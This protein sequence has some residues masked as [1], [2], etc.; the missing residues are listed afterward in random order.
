MSVIRAVALFG[1]LACYALQA[2]AEE[3]YWVRIR[4]LLNEAKTREDAEAARNYVES[5]TAEQLIIAGRQCGH[6]IQEGI[7]A[8]RPGAGEG[9]I[10]LA[11]FWEAYPRA[12]DNLRD[13]DPLLREICDRN[14]PAVWRAELARSLLAVGDDDELGTP[15]TNEQRQQV[16]ASLEPILG[17]ST[18][19]LRVRNAIPLSLARMLSAMYKD[20]SGAARCAA[21]DQR[22]QSENSLKEL[23]GRI[24]RY[25]ENTLV[26]FH[27]P[28]T[29]TAP[30]PFRQ[31][32]LESALICNRE[33]LP[34]SARVKDVVLG[35]LARYQQYPQAL[36][37][38]L[39]WAAIE[40]FHDPSAQDVLEEMIG[41][42]SN[43]DRN[44]VK[45]SLQYIKRRSAELRA[46]HHAKE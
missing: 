37:P 2:S 21:P 36:W 39:A 42:A 43:A 41:E 28:T 31:R 34:G 12:A 22:L 1:S 14:R 3:D 9:V 29:P 15:L 16:F 5:L 46:I 4:T 6:E 11:F 18:D 38:Q 35:A 27:D 7:D 23:S 10:A 8:G 25:V 30:Y 24:E 33:N 13:V 20:Y 40:D 19:C 26:I 45:K 32:V 44:S 17:D